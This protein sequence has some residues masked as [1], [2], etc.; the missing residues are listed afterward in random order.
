MSTFTGA[1]SFSF[2]IDVPAGPVG[3]KPQLSLSYSSASGDGKGGL[4][5]KQ[6]ASWV[7]RGWSL[8]T[9]SVNLNK[10]AVYSHQY[11]YYSFTFN[12]QSFDLFRGNGLV[13]SPSPYRP[14]EWAWSSTDETFAKVEAVV[15]GPSTA[16]R[17]GTK[18]GTPYTRFGWK[19]TT[20]DGT[21]YLFEEDAWWG[22]DDQCAGEPAYLEPYKWMLSTITDVHGNRITYSYGRKTQVRSTCNAITGTMDQDVWPTSIMWGANITLDPQTQQPIAQDRYRVAFNSTYRANDTQFDYAPNVIGGINGGAPRETQQLNSIQVLS[23]PSG[24]SW[25]LVRQYD[26]AYDYSLYSDKTVSGGPDT[27]Y[28]KLTLTSLTRK[29]NDGT[30]LPAMTFTYGTTRGSGTYPNGNWNRLVTANNGQGGTVTYGYETIGAVMSNNLFGNNRRVISRTVTDGRGNSYPTTYSYTGAAYNSVGYLLDPTQA[31]VQQF[32]NSATLYYAKYVVF[33]HDYTKQPELFVAHAPYTEFRGHSK[34]TEKDPN[35]NETDHYFYQ[36][37]VGCNPT[38]TQGGITADACFLQ[39]RDRE[40]LKGKEYRTVQ[41][42]G[43]STT[44]LRETQHNYTVE[45]YDYSQQPIVGL[46]RSFN[47]ENETVSI[48]TD[49]AP[50]GGPTSIVKRTKYYYVTGNQGGQQYGNLTKTEEYD[51]NNVLYRATETSYSPNTTTA[52]IVDKATMQT[53]KDNQGR[54]L[55]LTQWMYDGATTPVAPST[56]GLLTLVRKYYDVPLLVN[57]VGQTVRSSDT[58]LSYDSYGNQ[59]DVTTYAQ[60][61][62]R[63]NNGTTVTFSAPGNG[64]VASTVH[65]NYDTTFHAFSITV[66]SPTGN[67]NSTTLLESA[68]YD[69]RMGTMTSVTDPN[70]NTTTAEYDVFGRMVKLIKPGDSSALPTVRADYRDSELPFRYTYYVRNNSGVSGDVQTISQFYD[71]MGRKIQTKSE[72]VRNAQSM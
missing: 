54:L 50:A 38:A 65:T 1:A 45:F 28:P 18:N 24:T 26:F 19:V 23:L 30:P 12:G 14:W 31:A 6:Q 15:L 7:G 22:Y 59:T 49:P 72:S 46:W 13:A 58:S 57:L 39:L 34:V 10:A 3:I 5:T 43:T 11:D 56:R 21:V 9:G 20:K 35:G 4:R 52:Y 53:I 42:Q 2:P 27:A 63:Y 47:Y 29:G 51:A 61:G 60:P 62:T 8:A 32:A 16:T 25:Q 40:I 64:S 36:G 68:A 17:G 41:R 69:Y 44:V 67:N 66:T 48:N 71:G 70:N 33:G 37:D 55:G